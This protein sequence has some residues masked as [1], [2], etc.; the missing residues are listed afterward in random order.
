MRTA[1]AIGT[2]T[3]RPIYRQAT[4][5][6]AN[7]SAV[8]DAPGTGEL[9]LQGFIGIVSG[10]MMTALQTPAILAMVVANA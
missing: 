3:S 4:I 10:M 8:K 2:R 7:K 6:T 5:T 1:S 9:T